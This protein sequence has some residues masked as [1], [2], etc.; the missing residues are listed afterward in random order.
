WNLASNADL[1][2]NHT[3]TSNQGQFFAPGSATSTRAFGDLDATLNGSLFALPAG[4]ADV[5]FRVAGSA[6]HLD[7]EQE[8]FPTP[9]HGTT[10]RTT[11][12]AAISLDLPISHRG[13]SISALGNFTL[14]GDAR[15]EEVT[16][17]GAL[18][19]FGAGFNWS[20]IERLNLIAGWD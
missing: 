6:E 10:S 16:D 8:N 18:E 13:K 20:P 9:P 14:N 5:T 3:T 2:R 12:T 17:R 1:D 4:N 7:I 15:I 19:R 11:G